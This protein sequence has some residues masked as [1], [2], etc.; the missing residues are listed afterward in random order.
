[1][2]LQNHLFFIVVMLALIFLFQSCSKRTFMVRSMPESSMV[3]MGRRP[4]L[5]GFPDDICGITPI[6]TKI[7][8]VGKKDQYYVKAIHRGYEP[9]SVLVNKDSKSEITLNLTKIESF[10]EEQNPLYTVDNSDLYLFPVNTN[11]IFHKGV[12]NL[13]KYERSDE[14]S[15][16]IEDSINTKLKTIQLSEHQHYISDEYFSDLSIWKRLSDMLNESLLKLK[17]ELLIYYPLPPAIPA[18][19]LQI[20]N[21]IV[22]ANRLSPMK[23]TTRKLLVYVWCK[24]IKPT[25]GRVVGNI[26]ASLASGVVQGYD[27]ASYG[28]IITPYDPN[29]FNIDSSTLWMIFVFEPEKGRIIHISQHMLPFDITKSINRNKLINILADLPQLFNNKNHEK[30]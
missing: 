9:D 8:F 30:L 7:I 3:L 18:N 15:R 11:I 5:Y 28:T 21:S 14:L 16:E 4:N 27:A 22:D 12:G 2:K 6:N 26:T 20:M 29:A 24:S 17:P 25:T 1:M 10:R 13:D 23:D 19:H